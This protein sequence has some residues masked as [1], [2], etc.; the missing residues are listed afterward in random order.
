[1]EIGGLLYDPIPI[2]ELEC[3]PH[4]EELVELNKNYPVVIVFGGG[5]NVWDKIYND[6]HKAVKQGLLGSADDMENLA[7]IVRDVYQDKVVPR[8]WRLF[9]PNDLKGRPLQDPGKM[10]YWYALNEFEIL[11]GKNLFSL[12]AQSMGYIMVQNNDMT[13]SGWRKD[14]YIVSTGGQEA[15]LNLKAIG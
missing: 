4:F 14:N 12:I 11:L 10:M 6:L 13:G 3:A 2:H 5:G 8:T 15:I 1:M 9:E 7:L